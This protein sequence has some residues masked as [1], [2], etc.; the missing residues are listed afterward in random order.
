MENYA[1]RPLSDIKSM[2]FCIVVH[3]V[4]DL[5]NDI[6]YNAKLNQRNGG[7]NSGQKSANIVTE[8][9]MLNA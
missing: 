5:T 6:S 9:L 2:K 7:L 8:A 4:H 1:N 3:V